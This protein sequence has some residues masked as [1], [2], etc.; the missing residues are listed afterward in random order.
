MSS[1]ICGRCGQATA[2]N[3]SYCP[4]CRWVLS[5]GTIL[6]DSSE[7][8]AQLTF[9]MPRL[10]GFR[11]RRRLDHQRNQLERHIRD[12]I[13]PRVEEL[14][15]RLEED[16][17]NP[18]I[19]RDLAA[20]MVVER[21]WE[22]ANAHLQRA[23]QLDPD[24][25]ETHVNL[26]LV[27]ANRGQWQPALDILQAARERWPENPALYLNI[28]LVALHARRPKVSLEAISELERL[29]LEN[30][31][32]GELFHDDA[33]TARGLA[34]LQL[35]RKIE[36]RGALDSA[37]RRSTTL[38]QIEV[39]KAQVEGGEAPAQMEDD[40]DDEPVVELMENPLEDADQ[41]MAMSAA[42]QEAHAHH[43]VDADKLNNLAIVEAAVGELDDARVHLEAA[44]AMEPA[45]SVVLNNLAVLAYQAGH[46]QVAYRYLDV[47][48]QIE[49]LT[50]HH[51]PMTANH[52]GV[53]LSALGR[54][55][56]SLEQFQRAGQ[57]ER[58]EFEVFYNLGRAYI[59]HGM[60]ERGVEYLRQ[61]FRINP[62]QPDLHTVLGAAYLLR[63]R[64]HLIPEAIKHL[65]QTLKLRPHHRVAVVDLVMALLELQ[66]KD[67]ALKVLSQSLRADPKNPEAL[68]LVAIMIMERGDHDSWATAGVQFNSVL[69]HRPDMLACQFNTALCQYLLGFRDSAALQLQRL[70]DRDPSFAP[71]Y[72][73]M[74]VGHA[75]AKR[76]KEALAAWMQ[77]M[78]Y[79]PSRSDVNANIAF[80]YYQREEFDT[81]IKFFNQAHQQD[82]QD[83]ELLSALGICYAR[84]GRFNQ[85]L[86]AFESSLKINPRSPVTHSNIGLA[87]YLH[88]QVEKAIAHWRTVSQ[89]DQLYASRREEEQQ[90]A[91]DESP[92]QLRPLN[93]R[94]RIIM[95]APL[96]PAP[97]TQL[98]PGY[99]AGNYRPV[100]ADAELQRLYFLVGELRRMD[101]RLAAMSARY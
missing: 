62:T 66:Q 6:P 58:A 57:Q 91:F 90:R 15:L 8:V 80:I 45:H 43:T 95:Q 34:Y 38:G 16:P 42:G 87:Y 33:M 63:G 79:E 99:N 30:P 59:E 10:G 92:V 61:A 82:P 13:D 14:E 83:A 24:N 7:A 31:T 85:A 18:A 73:M 60:P 4:H 44:L 26:G 100:F 5:T 75:M 94:A 19:H 23:H 11:T 97:H 41:L 37:V 53:V 65:R 40:Q 86:A 28:A 29:S 35:D 1:L 93:W 72:Y 17:S 51:E 71:A 25:Y 88:K 48:R 74:G 98:Q 3:S 78:R 70:T 20:L 2:P 81:A 9:A 101:R 84:T 27:L 64:P 12:A 54:L 50:G 76:Y 77:T 32:I 49:E 67:E 21:H 55:A 22:R 52:L 39:L 56:E 47:A 89:L 96:L 36:A 68:F 69:L 46:F